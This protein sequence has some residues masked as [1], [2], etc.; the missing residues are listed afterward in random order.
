[1]VRKHGGKLKKPK[2]ITLKNKIVS[3]VV[4][5]FCVAQTTRHLVGMLLAFSSLCDSIAN[6]NVLNA[7]H[8]D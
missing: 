6:L 4:L 8:S 7:Y 3:C 5:F 1:M 2:E